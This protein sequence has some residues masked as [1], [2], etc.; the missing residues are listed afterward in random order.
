VR[1]RLKLGA[2]ASALAL[3][4]GL[5]LAFAGPAAAVNEVRMCVTQGAKG[6]TSNCAVDDGEH[7]PVTAAPE[8]GA[9]GSAWDAPTS[10]KAEIKIAGG[11]GYCMAVNSKEHDEIYLDKCNGKSYEEWDVIQG[12]TIFGNTIQIA[13]VYR[14]AWDTKLCLTGP[15]LH[16]YEDIY[17]KKCKISSQP[18]NWMLCNGSCG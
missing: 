3:A 17:A 1:L 13:Y 11:S 14:S 4:A 2:V 15:A 8:S 16:K 7:L 10:G 12:Q 9:G 18:D 5:G 6:Q